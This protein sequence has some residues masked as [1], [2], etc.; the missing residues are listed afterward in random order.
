M[1][2]W[3]DLRQVVFASTE[4]DLVAGTIRRELR[5][6]EGFGDPELASHGIADET[7]AVGA[8]TYLEVVSPLTADH[9]MASWLSFRGGT[10]GYLLSVQ[11]SDVDACL[12]RCAAAGIRVPLTQPVQGHRVA[13]LHRGDMSFGI[14]L[15]GISE[16]GRWFWDDL[17]VDRRA[18]ARVDE[19]TAVDIAVAEPAA[20]AERWAHVMG[21]DPAGP[22]SVDLGGRVIRFVADDEHRGIVGIE[23]HAV[24][25]TS[26][27]GYEFSVAGVSV[28]LV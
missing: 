1:S 21:L 8:H 17:P 19:V 14:E 28:R 20:V 18:D 5:L 7:M 4:P 23:L 16:R 2:A 10:A 11:V 9:P 25:R 13:Q 27:P 6:G 26:D 3:A 24:D 15:D 12:E 22:T